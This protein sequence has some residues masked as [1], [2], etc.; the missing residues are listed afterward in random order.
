MADEDEPYL[1]VDYVAVPKPRGRPRG[2]KT[3]PQILAAKREASVVAVDPPVLNSP[4]SLEDSSDV[5]Q[6]L[7]S[8]S[9]K[10]A[11][12]ELRGMA[13]MWRQDSDHMHASFKAASFLLELAG[14]KAGKKPTKKVEG[15][16]TMTELRAF[17]RQ[18]N[19][20]PSS[21]DE[22]DDDHEE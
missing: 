6:S 5:I 18:Q 7:A 17:L 14:G 2:S 11:M 22:G 9:V 12:D 3:S 8:Q 16:D 15:K 20:P 4:M 13:S 10:A 1:D 21:D 19:P